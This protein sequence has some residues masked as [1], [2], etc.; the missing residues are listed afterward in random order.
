MADIA[1]VADVTSL[2]LLSHNVLNAG[3][4]SE[5]LRRTRTILS[6]IG[7]LLSVGLWGLSYGNCGYASGIKVWMVSNGVLL[8]SVPLQIES[9]HW[10]WRGRRAIGS[11]PP[12]WSPH[13]FRNDIGQLI[14]VSLPL[15]IPTLVFGISLYLCRPLLHHYR[16]KRKKLGLCL[17]CGYDLRGS[18]DTCPECGCEFEKQ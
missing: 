6:L 2:G 3:K 17:K 14:W 15:W 10:F 1:S 9:P 8:R 12:L 18:K 4:D 5:M 11:F 7:L 16:R 13:V